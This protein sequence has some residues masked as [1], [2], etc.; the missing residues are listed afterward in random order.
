MRFPQED[1]N[2]H[3]SNFLEVCYTIKYNRVS[4]DVIR[5]RLFR[6]SLKNKAKHW[7]NS[8]PSNS[9]ITWDG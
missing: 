3:I 6:F 2:T 7:F 8:E 9:I 1:P 4:D 5:L